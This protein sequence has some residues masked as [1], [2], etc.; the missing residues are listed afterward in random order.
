MSLA[1]M[2]TPTILLKDD[3][4]QGLDLTRTWAI[5]RV[6]PDLI[7]DDGIASTS[8]PALYVRAAGTEI[9]SAV[10]VH[11]RARYAEAFDLG[12]SEIW[13]FTS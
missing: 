8:D 3:F 1:M 2:T 10:G 4:R 13:A 7:A 6:P 9:D 5:V 12:G 11:R